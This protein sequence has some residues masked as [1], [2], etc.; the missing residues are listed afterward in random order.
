MVHTP[1]YSTFSHYSFFQCEKMELLK[2]TFEEL[3]TQWTSIFDF[4]LNEEEGQ[5][6]MTW[7]RDEC[8]NY[9]IKEVE[10]DLQELF[11]TASQWIRNLRTAVK[12]KPEWFDL[13]HNK[14]FAR[15]FKFSSSNFSGQPELAYNCKIIC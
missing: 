4:K 3:F 2:Y 8:G 12:T 15:F 10:R 14:V 13:S 11:D 5:T 1:Y 7:L 6:V 9:S